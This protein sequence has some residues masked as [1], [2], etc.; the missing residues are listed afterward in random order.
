MSELRKW[1]ATSLKRME[2]IHPDLRKGLN[3]ALQLAPFPFRVIEGPRTLERQRQLLKI[4]ASKTLKSR[5]IPKVPAG[6]KQPYAHAFDAV[7]YVDLDK[8][9]TVETAEMFAWPLYHKLAPAIKAAFAEV[10]VP[11]EWGGDWRTFKDGP[12]WQ[13]PWKVYP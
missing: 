6:H 9:G 4:G 7:P 2:G 12:H 5:H 13:L 10:G 1:D 11:I 3:V 8:D